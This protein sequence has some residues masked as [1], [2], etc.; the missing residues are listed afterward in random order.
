[1]CEWLRRERG[2]Q[3]VGSWS[4]NLTV[5]E[6]PWK[7]NGLPPMVNIMLIASAKSRS[8]R[9]A[10]HQPAFMSSCLTISHTFY[11]PYLPST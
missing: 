2:I 4:R 1:M 11:L 10:S 8:V 6:P 5:R 3:C 7:Q 9:G